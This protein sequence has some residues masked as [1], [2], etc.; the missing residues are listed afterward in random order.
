MQIEAGTAMRMRR[1]L[2]AL[3]LIGCGAGCRDT[4]DVL[5]R[6]YRNLHNEAVDCL[7]MITG[8]PQAKAVKARVLDQFG[9]RIKSVTDRTKNWKQNAEK[10]DYG[11]QLL[12]SDSVVIL[13]LENEMNRERLQLESARL[14]KLLEDLVAAETARRRQAGDNNPVN[15]KLEW[16][17]LSDL[18]ESREAIE[19]VKA[20]L[21][22]GG[23]VLGVL[24]EV[25]TDEKLLGSPKMKKLKE[26]F[27]KKVEDFKQSRLL[28]IK[29]A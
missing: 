4:A 7:M 2:G 6:D 27:D 23:D 28:K 26:D 25:R 11:S 3:M 20:Q 9:T 22:Q 5:S 24:N 8:E 13:M 16:P 29:Q 12:T 17:T 19:Q 14:K 15:T 1:V 21:E 18:V 10:T